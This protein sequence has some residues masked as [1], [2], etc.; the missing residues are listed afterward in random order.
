MA[1]ERYTLDRLVRLAI[2]VSVVGGLIWI[3]VETA[4]VLVPLAAG[5]L[6]AYLLDPVV[7]LVQRLIKNRVVAVLVTV[8]LAAVVMAAVVWVV[9]PPIAHEVRA[10]AK[11]SKALV[12]EGS[13]LRVRLSEWLPEGVH[14]EIVDVARDQG[15]QRLLAENADLRAVA[16]AGV[17]RILPGL[18]GVVSGSL[19]VL[20]VL[21]QLFLVVVYVIFLLVDFR[22]FQESWPDYLPPRYRDGVLGFVAEFNDALARYFR[23]R[24]VLAIIGAVLFAAGF[25]I[26]GIDLA[27]LLGLLLGLLGMVPYL[28]LFGVV[29][30]YGVAVLT[31]AQ[32]DGGLAWYLIGVTIV[33]VVVQILTDVLLAPKILGDATG[34]R[35]ILILV[36]VMFWGKLLGF[37]GVLLAIP[38]TCLGLAYYRRYLGQE[39]LQATSPPT[40]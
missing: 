24:F 34:L 40:S 19:A 27:I 29:P 30:A 21:M 28:Q 5:V 14:Q 18:W 10:A 33:F 9:V 12:I 1:E 22:R 35:P 2:T 16:W 31:A 8:A 13:P 4:D 39:R 36:A 32:T 37:L 23:G 6:V 7:R 38:L 11:L 17:K 26:V 3:L 20:G 25:S 15:L